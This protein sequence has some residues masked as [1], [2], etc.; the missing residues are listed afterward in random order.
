MVDAERDSCHLGS[1]HKAYCLGDFFELALM[2]GGFFFKS[3]G[4]EHPAN[5]A[6]A[7]APTINFMQVT[8]VEMRAM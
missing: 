8:P 7:S 1:T 4:V 2:D 6:T 3:L 5:I